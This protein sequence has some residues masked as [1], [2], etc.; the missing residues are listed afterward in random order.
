MHL[1]DPQAS[2]EYYQE[3]LIS[4]HK[5]NQGPST[6]G[7]KVQIQGIGFK[8]FY[9]QEGESDQEAKRDQ[10]RLW[11]RMVNYKTGALIHE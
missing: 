1:K 5:P 3:P 10:N 8:T 11:L 6:G 7:T 9:K 2:Y 4:F